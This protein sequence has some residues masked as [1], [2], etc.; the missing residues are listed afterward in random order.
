MNEDITSNNEQLLPDGR[1]IKEI[2]SWK[3]WNT[4][5]KEVLITPIG[6]RPYRSTVKTPLTNGVSV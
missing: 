5:Y 3:D 4:L 1:R 2:R 6:K